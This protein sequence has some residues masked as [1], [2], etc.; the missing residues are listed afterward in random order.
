MIIYANSLTVDKHQSLC[1]IFSLSKV[2]CGSEL[3]LLFVET[4]GKG[5]IP[6]DDETFGAFLS[7]LYPSI[8][9]QQFIF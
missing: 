1:C 3:A 7:F 8:F 6:Y 9:Y 4:L 2:T 5:K